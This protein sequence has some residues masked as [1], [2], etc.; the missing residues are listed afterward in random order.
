MEKI[1]R[2]LGM[3]VLIAERKGASDVR[4]GR[5]SFADCLKLGTLFILVAP[6]DSTTKNMF[7]TSEFSAMDPA[8]LIINVG[9][10]GVINE[11]DLAEALRQGE[12][13][14]AGLDVFE[15]EPAS[16]TNSPLVKQEIPNLILSPHLAWYVNVR[17][18][19]V[20]EPLTDIMTVSL[21]IFILSR[22]TKR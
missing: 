17:D 3:R 14:G 16:A 10:G 22:S 21:N 7:G 5:T 20:V 12:I 18:L 1:G 6:L 15:T 4:D 2:A 11:A 9:R 13:G 19:D 8:A